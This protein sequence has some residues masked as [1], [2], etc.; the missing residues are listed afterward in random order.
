MNLPAEKFIPIHAARAP[1]TE[2]PALVVPIASADEANTASRFENIVNAIAEGRQ[3]AVTIE[4]TSN[5]NLA[6]TFCG[7]HSADYDL[8]DDSGGKAVRKRKQHLKLPVFDAFRE[9]MAGMPPLKVL[10]FHGHG[11]PLLNKS[12]ATMVR[13]AR[14]A[15]LTESVVI[16][17]N[18]TLLTPHKLRQL[19][20]A[21]VDEIRVSLDVITPAT[22]ARIKGA[23][24]GEQV[25]DNILACLKTLR[26]T[27]TRLRLA[28]DCM[29]WRDPNSPLYAE[30]RLIEARLGDE[31]ART[32]NASIRWRDEF[33]W[34]DQMGHRDEARERNLPCEQ[35]FYMLMI[36][37]D[38][39]VSAC[40]AD[41]AQG[42]VVG[43]IHEANHFRDIIR[44][45]P[46]RQVRTALLNG[47]F[48]RLPQCR[49]CDIHSVVDS[50]LENGKDRLLPIL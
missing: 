28:I 10:Y 46:L 50:A 37:A 38:G 1:R 3:I 16:V 27:D 20:D 24:M 41:S 12:L 21:G 39:K 4:A 15:R 18:G 25:V 47:D 26:D 23:D 36:H 11:E 13:S 44:G 2:T 49:K 30:N 42:L 43:N 6:C 40:C 8:D 32:P 19:A 9:K 5:C 29:K 35:A 33:G 7:M 34:V 22:Y 14:E 17:S 48:D 31:V 45:A